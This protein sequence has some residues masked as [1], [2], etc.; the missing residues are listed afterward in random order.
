M[1]SPTFTL[2][3]S[4]DPKYASEASFVVLIDDNAQDDLDLTPLHCALWSSRL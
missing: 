1:R 3:L 2:L 4:Y